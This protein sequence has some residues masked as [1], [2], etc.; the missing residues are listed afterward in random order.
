MASRVRRWRC[1][2]VKRF[3]GMVKGPFL[4]LVSAASA[5]DARTAGRLEWARYPIVIKHNGRPVPKARKSAP[6][7]AQYS[8]ARV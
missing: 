7:A 4:G 2:E 1:Y 8:E 5:E 6:T 3:F